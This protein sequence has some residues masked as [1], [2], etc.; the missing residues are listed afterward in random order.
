MPV[1]HAELEEL[2]EKDID[3]L[4]ILLAQADPDNAEIMF[5]AEEARET[6]RA[7][8]ARLSGR[9][10]ERICVEWRYCEKRKTG[11]FSDGLT[12][13]A[14]VADV[15]VTVVGGIPAGT[16]ATLAVKLGLSRLCACSDG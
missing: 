12:L 6:G 8:Y 2:H 5:S 14:A 15:I 9:L 7:T 3:E 1:D 4:Y 16:V 11:A 10:H 13:T